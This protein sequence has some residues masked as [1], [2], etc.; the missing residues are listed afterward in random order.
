M[1]V[2]AGNR[3]SWGKTSKGFALV[4][5]DA[6]ITV[7]AHAAKKLGEACV[8]TLKSFDWMWPRGAN[9]GPYKSG[10]RGGNAEYPWYSGNLHD[11]VAAGVADGRRLLQANFMTPGAQE[12][13]T[14]KGQVIDGAS[15][16]PEAL[17]RAVQTFGAGVGGLRAML[18]VGVPYA[19]KVNES[20]E[21]SGYISNLEEYFAGEVLG[22]LNEL[23]KRSF[24]MK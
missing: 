12:S 16:G 2:S 17:N 11:S 15:L 6:G 8:Q 14:Y 4:L 5:R 23:P 18:V 19:E 22:I 20:E 7:T 24:K 1:A 3:M 10:Y 21:H 13:Q 9:N